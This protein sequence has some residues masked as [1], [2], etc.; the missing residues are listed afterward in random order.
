M[1]KKKQFDKFNYASTVRSALSH[2]ITKRTAKRTFHE[3]VTKSYKSLSALLGNQH[4]RTCI[5]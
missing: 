1:K 5:V 3:K 2:M 4:Q